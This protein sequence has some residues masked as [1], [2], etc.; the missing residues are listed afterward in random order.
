MPARLDLDELTEQ[1]TSQRLIFLYKVVE[2]LVPAIEAEKYQI[3]DLPKRLLRP[4]RHID[5]QTHNIIDKQ[6]RNNS[7]CFE[8]PSTV[9]GKDFKKWDY[10]P[11][12][13]HTNRQFCIRMGQS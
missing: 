3:P 5:F 12:S 2:G 9:I 11:D 6:M 8:V 13:E 4:K 10:G 1:R 7:K